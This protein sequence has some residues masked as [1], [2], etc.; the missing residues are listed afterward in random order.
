[1]SGF[2]YG[3]APPDVAALSDGGR[4]GTEGGVVDDT[5]GV[6]EEAGAWGCDDGA[7]AEAAAVGPARS[8]GFGGDTMLVVGERQ[9]V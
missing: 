8:H 2:V 1:M 5:C 3:E 4:S 7:A 9:L 6:I